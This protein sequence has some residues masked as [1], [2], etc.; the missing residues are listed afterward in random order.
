MGLLK[1]ILGRKRS[2]EEKPSAGRPGARAYA[3]GDIHGR[4]DLLDVLLARIE[5][6]VAGREEKETV[7]VFLGDLIDRGPDSAGVVERLRTFRPDYAETVFLA[8]NHE[9][10]MLRILEGD[11][12]PLRQWLRYGGAECVESYGVNTEELLKLTRQGA[13]ELLRTKVPPSHIGFLRDMKDTFRFGE[14]LFVHAGIR[15]GV[16]LEDQTLTDL[17]WIR[18]PFLSHDEQHG[19][20]V[21][22]GHTIVDQVEERCNR[23]AIDTGAYNS[24]VLTALAV[25]DDRRWYLAGSID[26]DVETLFAAQ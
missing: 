8:G 1:K 25:E 17:R 16:S 15:P 21:V 7:I 6:D 3:I 18:E 5:A 14:Y 24:G 10:L 11:T 12:K 20:V 22:H 23:I 26:G 13:L 2:V 9:E 19:F 4:L